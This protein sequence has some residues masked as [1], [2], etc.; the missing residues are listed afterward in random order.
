MYVV[1]EACEDVLNSS[2][3]SHLQKHR[4]PALGEK[5]SVLKLVL[6]Q[7]SWTW[8]RNSAE[9][10]RDLRERLAEIQSYPVSE[11]MSAQTQSMDVKELAA[12][13]PATTPDPEETVSTGPLLISDCV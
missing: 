9:V 7:T 3:S 8:T 10:N 11:N 1:Q 2:F 5:V 13:T 6:K 12:A 4:R